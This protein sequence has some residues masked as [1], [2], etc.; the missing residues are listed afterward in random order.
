G[1]RG[2]VKGGGSAASGAAGAFPVAREGPESGEGLAVDD[3]TTTAAAPAAA[4]AAEGEGAGD[5]GS[6][7]LL[8]ALQDGYHNRFTCPTCNA[9]AELQPVTLPGGR[10][11]G[12]KIV[13][14]TAAAATGAVTTN[15]STATTSS[16]SVGVPPLPR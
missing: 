1:K 15:S 7:S 16:V 12:G 5:D 8:S 4:A 10:G 6:T 9:G 2:A 14:K 11:R 13:D 3:A